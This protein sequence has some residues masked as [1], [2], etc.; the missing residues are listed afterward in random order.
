MGIIRK[1]LGPKSKY[2]R[3]IPYTY[4]AKVQVIQNDKDLFNQY[5]SDTIC[6][7]IEYLDEQNIHPDEV[8]LFGCYLKKEIP[9][10]KK[11]C[12]N[13][14]GQWLKR[15]ELCRSLENHYQQS[16]EEQYKG[17]V[18]LGEC[19]FEDRDRKQF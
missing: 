4:F 10:D 8:E 7:L 13:E 19:S 18:E 16:L 1:I 12:L 9:I 5:F 17:H 2:D 11:Y 3:T 15:P 14:K 6:G